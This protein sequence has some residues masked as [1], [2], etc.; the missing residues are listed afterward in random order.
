MS[1]TS[2][3]Q[4]IE[5]YNDGAEAPLFLAGFFQSPPQNFHTSEKVEIDIVREDEDVAVAITGV[6]EGP[7]ANES[8]RYTN[9]AFTPP[10][11]D[12]MGPIAAYDML[13]R[14]AGQNPF[15]SPDFG[16][17]AT[18]QAF[19]IFR[20]LENKIRRAVELQASQIFQSGILTL[21]DGA[22]NTVYTLDFKPKATHFPTVAA[23]WALDGSTGTPLADLED[24]SNVIRRDGKR[25][26]NRL[27]FG[28]DAMN[29]FLANPKVIEELNF[30]RADLIDLAPEVRGQGA[31]F[32]GTI[33]IGHYRFEMWMYD[34]TFKN[35]SSGAVTPYVGDDRVIMLSSEGRLDLT[36]GAIPSFV[37]PEQRALPFLPPRITS[38]GRGIALDTNSWV[39]NDGKTLFVSAGTRPLTIPTAIDTFGAL[40]GIS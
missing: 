2:T 37:S 39:T 16:A 27:I 33:V 10:V 17:S 20:K 23:V 3:I 6:A 18:L 21:T 32:R 40:D 11:Y 26:P 34:G 1:D 35:P 5:I 22:A 38:E 12:E 31:T 30:R 36:F 13:K 7:R 8:S 15:D 4:M 25:Q 29:R 28:P 9:K 14:Q 24:L 19:T